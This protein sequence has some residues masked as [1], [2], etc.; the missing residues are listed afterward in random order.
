[1]STQMD[2]PVNTESIELYFKPTGTTNFLMSTLNL[3]TKDRVIMFDGAVP[4]HKSV[5]NIY[6]FVY[7]YLNL[8]SQQYLYFISAILKP[9]S[10]SRPETRTLVK[11]DGHSKRADRVKEL[12]PMIDRIIATYDLLFSEFINEGGR[13]NKSYRTDTNR[14][15]LLKAYE[16][17]NSEVKKNLLDIL[18]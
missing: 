14:S 1:M 16:H 6:E 17:Y 7:S 3:K 2:K 8:C 12:A 18:S 9:E 11:L 10:E 15:E 13:I 4:L 5:Y